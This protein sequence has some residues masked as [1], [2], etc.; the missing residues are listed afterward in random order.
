MY[1]YISIP[2]KI[3]L[4]ETPI[5]IGTIVFTCIPGMIPVKIPKRIPIKEETKYIV[6]IS[7]AIFA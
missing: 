2:E 5:K 6:I 7:T 4:A 3:E 1:A